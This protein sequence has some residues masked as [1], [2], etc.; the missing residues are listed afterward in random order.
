MTFAVWCHLITKMDL[1]KASKVSP[2]HSTIK[3]LGYFYPVALQP[4]FDLGGLFLKF[5]N[6]KQ[7]DTHTWY[8]S[9]EWV[10]S[11][12]QRPLPTRNTTDEQPWPQQVRPAIP[13]IERLQTYVLDRTATGIGRL[14]NMNSCTMVDRLWNRIYLA[15]YIMLKMLALKTRAKSHH[16][17]KQPSTCLFVNLLTQHGRLFFNLSFQITHRKNLKVWDYLAHHSSGHI[18]PIRFNLMDVISLC[19]RRSIRWA[20]RTKIWSK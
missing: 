3:R 1:L 11:S 12:S 20:N 17:F 14:R 4:K 9:S 15:V 5:L 13:A 8:Q 6:R 18:R 2:R 19:F 7:L 16:C 10:I